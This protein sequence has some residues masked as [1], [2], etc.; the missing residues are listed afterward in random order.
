MIW[1]V[2]MKAMLVE[3][4]G[5]SELREARLWG[6]VLPVGGEVYTIR[7]IIH[8]FSQSGFLLEEID[9]LGVYPLRNFEPGFLIRRFRPVV[10]TS[11]SIFERLLSPSPSREVETV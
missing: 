11:I 8:D 7:D 2:G 5:G 3:G 6:V 4:F 9:N 1:R 10:S